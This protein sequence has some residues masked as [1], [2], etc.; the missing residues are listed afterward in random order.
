MTINGHAVML[1]T[2][3]QDEIPTEASGQSCRSEA[4]TPDEIAF[5]RASLT[6]SVRAVV[7][8]LK[9]I[10]PL[11]ISEVSQDTSVDK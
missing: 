3:K 9:T 7:Q 4:E 11:D 1:S 8:D 10:F 5:V 6:E 2:A